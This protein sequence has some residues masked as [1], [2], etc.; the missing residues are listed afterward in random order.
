[1]A[2]SDICYL[3][4]EHNYHYHKENVL[5]KSSNKGGQFERGV[6]CDCEEVGKIAT[7]GFRHLI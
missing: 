2:Y 1:M 3:M 7:G 5:Y 6:L 4:C